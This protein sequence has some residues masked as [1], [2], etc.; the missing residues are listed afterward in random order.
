MVLLHNNQWLL[1]SRRFIK[2]FLAKTFLLI[3]VLNSVQTNDL[4]RTKNIFSAVLRFFEHLVLHDF[5]LHV[6][7]FVRNLA[8]NCIRWRFLWIFYF[9]KLLKEF[10]FG[11]LNSQ[12]LIRIWFFSNECNAMLFN[13]K[14]WAWNGSAFVSRVSGRQKN[15]F[16]FLKFVF[17]LSQLGVEII[18]EVDW[19]RLSCLGT[20]N[21]FLSVQVVFLWQTRGIFSC[22]LVFCMRVILQDVIISILFTLVFRL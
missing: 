12:R 6:N 9:S 19:H 5:N 7:W 14:L 17:T 4:V 16:F 3:N 11:S 15:Y 1:F 8:V 22:V 21:Y 2:F 13:H 20:H 18:L 10:L